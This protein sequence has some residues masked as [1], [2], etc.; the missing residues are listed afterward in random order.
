MDSALAKKWTVIEEKA[1][2]FST[3]RAGASTS[4]T[5]QGQQ[6]EGSDK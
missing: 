3:T 6:V 1:E 2:G 5:S 4:V